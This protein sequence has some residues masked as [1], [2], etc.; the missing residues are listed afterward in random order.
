MDKSALE[1]RIA[2]HSGREHALVVGRGTTA[3][4]LALKALGLTAKKVIIPNT[5]CIDIANAVIYSGNTPLFCDTSLLDCNIDT[6]QIER[7]FTQDVRVIIAVHM[8]GNPAPIDKIKSFCTER[9]VSLIEDAA[10]AL[11]ATAQGKPAGYFGDVSIFS[12]GYTK[13]IDAGFGGAI[14]TDDETVYRKICKLYS[15]I[16][17]LNDRIK[18]RIEELGQLTRLLNRF[19]PGNSK[20]YKL[21]PLLNQIY[22]ES[23][24]FALPERYINSIARA[25]DS[26]PANIKRRQRKAQIYA[27]LLRG[28]ENIELLSPREG[29]I[30]WR[31]S[32]FLKSG[33]VRIVE[34]ARK[35]GIDISTWYPALHRRYLH[36]GNMPKQ[37][38]P[39]S[40][41]IE[42]HIV[43]LWVDDSISEERVREN[44]QWLLAE[45]E[46]T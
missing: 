43:N 20:L 27:E 21:Y 5:A 10:L 16:P 17:V 44:A 31:F 39:N 30:V 23:Y 34:N 14:V 25:L 32:F 15:E 12:F 24:L 19:A 29:A 3:I 28:H 26:L 7:V 11:G 1:A 42:N 18:A 45:M 37:G 35:H 41:Y 2:A 13:I 36:T 40:T 9:G 8:F 38:F 4:Y 6:A 22:R 46:R 33:R